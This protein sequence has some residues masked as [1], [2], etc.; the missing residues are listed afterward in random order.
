VRVNRLTATS[1]SN[2]SPKNTLKPEGEPPEMDKLKKVVFMAHGLLLHSHTHSQR[3]R[4]SPSDSPL[5]KPGA[6]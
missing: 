5:F 2:E 3:R 1:S 4:R 6:S